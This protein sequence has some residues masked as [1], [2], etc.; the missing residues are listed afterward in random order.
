MSRSSTLALVALVV[1]AALPQ[2][3]SAY[4]PYD[5]AW[6]YITY[7]PGEYGAGDTVTFTV[8]VV[9][10]GE[11]VRPDSLEVYRVV[12]RPLACEEVAVGTYRADYRI[13]E[14]DAGGTSPGFYISAEA[15]LNRTD[16]R[17][18]PV[19]IH[20]DAGCGFSF[21][22]P[23][24]LD[25]SIDDVTDLHPSPGGI[26]EFTVATLFRGEP[27]DLEDPPNMYVSFNGS[28]WASPWVVRT[29]PGLYQG[30]FEAPSDGGLVRVH[31]SG[32]YGLGWDRY[33]ASDD[34]RVSVEPIQVWC[35]VVDTLPY[36]STVELFFVDAD[37]APVAGAE[38]ELR[39]RNRQAGWY[40]PS[41]VSGVTDATG[42]VTLLLRHG[43][44]DEECPNV[45]VDGVA[46]WG[47][48]T[49]T[50][51]GE[52]WVQGFQRW[53]RGANRDLDVVVRT[54]Q[55]IPPGRGVE[56]EH[57][58]TVNGTPL[59][60][61]ELV[62]YV[63]DNHTLYHSGRVRTDA[64]GRFTVPLDL[65]ASLRD[66]HA[67]L[68]ARYQ[69]DLDGRMR[70]DFK[71]LTVGNY[72]RWERLDCLIDPAVTL[73]VG[74][75]AVDRSL[76]VSLDHPDADGAN[77]TAYLLWGVGPVPDWT[78]FGNLD[79]ESWNHLSPNA[80]RTVPLN[81]SDGSYRG[82]IDLPDFLTRSAE[83]FVYGVLDLGDGP[84]VAL[85]GGLTPLMEN[86]A[87]TVE[88]YA[89]V[90]GESYWGKIVCAGRSSDDR[91]V[92]RVEARLDGGEWER[93]SGTTMWTF[94]VDTGRLAEGSHTLE[95]RAYDGYLFSETVPVAFDVL[96]PGDEPALP[97]EGPVA[98]VLVLLAVGLT[99]VV[100]AVALRRSRGA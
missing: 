21:P 80:L 39:G 95:V 40:T 25:L 19:V 22:R 32:S 27:V 57:T 36:K 88:V 7:P 12:G 5:R 66:G 83:V 17:G 34:E 38:V 73:S 51:R 16:S 81:W 84:A 87:P 79:W 18:D 53:C 61:A 54:E 58:A 76:E 63:W 6:V 33:G 67:F 55:P 85:R 20:L 69:Y 62:V 52:L 91:S 68:N 94:D 31:A 8:H 1:L 98:T 44:I 60:D 41:T 100:V 86:L 59:A 50:F 71:Y 45:V 10:E 24:V 72:S 14:A 42:R 23:F 89:P 11:H 92:A 4:Y 56:V 26:V 29:G 75:Y 35:H 46:R 65:P 47:N 99:A 9:E 15:E 3:A 37:G 48:V 82:S 43:D 64:G 70:H 74:P 49:Q 96:E 78:D 90:A 93:V 30:L 28:S 2:D 77:E 13:T 97:V